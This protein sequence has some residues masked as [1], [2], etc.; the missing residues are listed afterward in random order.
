MNQKTLQTLRRMASIILVFTL[1]LS[2][3]AVGDIVISYNRT[4]AKAATFTDNGSATV[5][6]PTFYKSGQM[7]AFKNDGTVEYLLGNNA[8]YGVTNG[9]TY[10][11]LVDTDAKVNGTT[12]K[13]DWWIY[14]DKPNILQN[15]NAFASTYF[16]KLMPAMIATD[17]KTNDYS[18][19][20]IALNGA[21]MWPLSYTQLINNNALRTKF[22]SSVGDT[23]W[24][25]SVEIYNSANSRAYVLSVYGNLGYGS[26]GTQ[27][28]VAPAF[29]LDLTKVLLAK[30][31]TTVPS[32]GTFSSTGNNLV[33]NTAGGYANGFTSST[34]SQKTLTGIVGHTYSVAYSGATAGGNICA[35]L[36]K[37][38]GSVAYY[39]SL[40][41]ASTS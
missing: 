32:F 30:N 27:Y 2:L 34:V 11:E 14:S 18:E 28:K 6:V 15:T 25:R 17:I 13:S 31:G 20:S 9:T 37:S 19:C 16:Q 24:T 22:A 12:L 10:W 39:G 5:T 26:C 29:N 38:D 7:P 3:F 36:Y 23:S 35:A 21:H 1:V 4:N 41:T 8:W 40:G 33:V